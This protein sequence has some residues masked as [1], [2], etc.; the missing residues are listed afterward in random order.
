MWRVGQ[1]FHWGGGAVSKNDGSPFEFRVDKGALFLGTLHMEEMGN[2]RIAGLGCL[3]AEGLDVWDRRKMLAIMATT[4]Y[5]F[6]RRS[7]NE[8]LSKG[9]GTHETAME[10]TSLFRLSL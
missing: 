7:S 3:W 5:R 1:E 4:Y 8:S 10:Y 9:R 6:R 2:L